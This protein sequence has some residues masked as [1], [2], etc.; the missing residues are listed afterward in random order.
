MKMNKNAFEVMHPETIPTVL[1]SCDP[2]A[3]KVNNFH[4]RAFMPSA[5]E[6]YQPLVPLFDTMYRCN[7]GDTVSL[8][9]NGDGGYVTTAAHISTAIA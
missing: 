3:V 9:L 4:H 1:M 8:V 6:D 2:D 7:H 5:L